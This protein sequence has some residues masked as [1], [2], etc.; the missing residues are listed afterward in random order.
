MCIK[1]SEIEGNLYS[2]PIN[3]FLQQ[4]KSI[5]GRIRRIYIRC[6]L[7]TYQHLQPVHTYS[8]Y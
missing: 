5:L 3:L 6:Y 2:C 8:S 7:F 4:V 1:E